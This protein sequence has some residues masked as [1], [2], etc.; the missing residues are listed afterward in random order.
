LLQQLAVISSE[1]NCALQ[2]AI[3]HHQKVSYQEN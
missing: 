2:Q 1:R 3:V